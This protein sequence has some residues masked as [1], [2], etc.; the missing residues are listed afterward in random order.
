MKATGIVLSVWLICGVSGPGASGAVSW[1]GASGA[2]PVTERTTGIREALRA[3]REPQDSA[4]T[5]VWW[6]HGETRT[7]REGITADLE[8]F[9]A[10]GVGG[11]VYY[12]QVH[13]PAE[14][15]LDA[16]SPQWWEMLKFAALEAQRLGLS[17]EINLS[18]GYVAGGPWITP[19]TGMQRL[20]SSD[21]LLRGGG[22]FH[23]RLAAPSRQ[24]WWRDVAVLAWPVQAGQWEER[25]LESLS[26]GQ[27]GGFTARNITYTA[28]KARKSRNGAMNYPDGPRP[29]FYG[30]NF[31][32]YGTV[33]TLECSDDGVN[34]LGVCDLPR[35][36]G[37]SGLAQRT[38]AFPARTA[39]YWRIRD[40]AEGLSGVVLSAVPRIGLWQQ[41]ANYYSDFQDAGMTPEAD[42][43]GIDPGGILDLG[44][45]LRSDGTLDWTVPEGDWVVM[46][47]GTESTRGSVKHGR[48]NL[49]GL[50]CDKLSREAARLH[51]NAYAARILDTLARIGAAPLGVTMDSHEAGPQNWTPDFPRIFREHNGYDLLPWLPAMR[52]YTVGT[53][54]DSERFLREVR[55]TIADAVAE[56]YY[57]TLDSLC[58]AAGVR[59]TAQATGNQLS[60]GAD[61]IGAKRLVDKPQGEFWAR[62]IHGSYDIVDC[63]SAAHLYGRPV[64]SG[65]AFTDAKYSDSPARLKMLADFA[66]SRLINEFVVCASAY[67][68]ELDAVPGNVANGRQYCLNRNNPVWPYSRPFWD[69]QAR[70]AGM[71]RQGE[72]VV[73]LLVYLGDAPPVKTL[74]HL[75]PV[76]PEGYNFDT[77]AADGLRGAQVA[78]LPDGTSVLHLPSG[79]EYRMLLIQRNVAAD[80]PIRADFAAWQAA[81]LPVFDAGKAGSIYDPVP[82]PFGPDLVFRSA[83]RLDDC[84]RFGHRRLPDAD[85]YFVYK[86]GASGFGQEVAVRSP[87]RR[88]YRLDPLDGTVTA[89]PV[90]EQ[91]GAVRTFLMLEADESAFLVATDEDLA[92]DGLALSDAAYGHRHYQPLADFLL[93]ARHSGLDPEPP[94]RPLPGPWRVQFDPAMGGPEEAVRFN[95]LTDWTEHPDP[96]IRYYSGTAVYTKSFRWR[97]ARHRHPGLDPESPRQYLQLDASGWIARVFVNGREAGTVWCAPWRLDIT[98][99]LEPGRNELRIEVVNSLYN[100]MIGDAVEYPDEPGGH[101]T[102]SSFPLVD[103][104]TPLVPS[105]L[106]GVRIISR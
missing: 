36:G 84:V 78:R 7:T 34:W 45:F 26:T 59:F 94:S 104:T 11:V 54:S 35:P 24:D 87:Y 61:N 20:C 74:S 97:S 52:G 80:D 95:Q 96:R 73:D 58:R 103:A 47:F 56:N 81:G 60:L 66:Y 46:R 49:L 44:A 88:L 18:N 42:L 30:M 48:A 70:C 67:Q 4:R 21:T 106:R 64:A 71:L 72:P 14:G 23:G 50:E 86:H 27:E 40:A 101:Y 68:P 13:G 65:E 93:A 79:M 75:L 55:R 98:D 33:G 83:A 16:F 10:A 15:A 43:S 62:D 90:G 100:R 57:G 82:I 63:T 17:F 69:Y 22:R 8:A 28:P 3:F 12:D 19:E 91:V 2:F 85:I 92:A 76:V 37:G 41:K 99:Y 32:P 39:R 89:L 6:F 51:F 25:S 9:R 29:E 77:T 38:V 1:S 5:K 31:E 53:A 102:R 105:G